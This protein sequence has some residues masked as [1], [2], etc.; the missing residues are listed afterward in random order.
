MTIVALLVIALFIARALRPLRYLG[1]ATERIAEGDLLQAKAIL[2]KHPVHSMDEIGSAYASTKRMSEK[3]T[4]LV[5]AISSNVKGTA[6]Q[7]AAS[8]EVM[9]VESQQLVNMNQVVNDTAQKV[10]EGAQTQQYSASE[11]ARSMLEITQSIGRVSEAA[12]HVS[13]ASQTA[14]QS[15]ESGKNTIQ[16][17]KQQIG[18]IAAAAQDTQSLVQALGG[19]SQQIG[20]VLRVVV[21]I[22]NQTKLLA[23]NASIEAA[24]A[25]EHGSG[26]AV[27]ASEVRKLAEHS[28]SSTSQ[29]SALLT[30]IQHI[31]VQINETMSTGASEVQAGIELSKEVDESFHR[32]VDLFRFVTTQIQEI[33]A[34]AEQISAGSQEVAASVGEISDIASV[35]SAGTHEI[36]Q[37]A[38]KQLHAAQQISASVQQLSGMTRE[39]K[40]AIEKITV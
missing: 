20:E 28:S 12:L 10:D 31:S 27:V 21:D 39:M 26:F 33:S 14:L 25:G 15:A 9:S 2:L 16:L 19:Y 23:L 38:H 5:G 24:R 17:M 13:D 29:I 4:E 8:L 1:E 18:T 6:D 30:N 11:S 36:N 34:S 32:V 35:S 40:A 7:L 37:L 3:L 22:A